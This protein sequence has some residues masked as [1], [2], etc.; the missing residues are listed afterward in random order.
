ML[1]MPDARENKALLREAVR[2]FMAA[3]A[4]TG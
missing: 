4:V 2:V 3:Y 1:E